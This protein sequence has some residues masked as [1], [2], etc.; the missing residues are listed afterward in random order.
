MIKKS[1]LL[2]ALAIAGFAVTSLAQTVPN[3]VPSNGLV[4]W[5]PFNGNAIDESVNTNDGTVTGATLTADR[6]GSVN[7]AY[8]FDGVNDY[9]EVAHNST[10]DIPNVTISAW[11]NAVSYT[12][13]L[14]GASRLIASK[15][16]ISGW[17][18]SFQFGLDQ[19]ILNNNGFHADWTIGGN[20][21]V[22][23]SNQNLLINNW[24]HAVYVH[25][26][27][28]AFLYLNGNKVKSKSTSGGLTYNTLPLWFGARPNAGNNSSWFS[29]KLDDIGIWNRAL[30]PNEITGLYNA[31]L[32]FQTI[33]VT[34][35]LLIN[36][37]LT[38]FNPIT[39][40][41]TIKIWPNPSNDHITIDNGNL[42]NL[43]GH[44]IKIS[45]ALGQQVFQSAITQQQFYVDMSTWGGN[46]IYF[47]NL[48]NAQGVTIETRKIVLQ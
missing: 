11:Y 40:Q 1:V 9:I 31:N 42:A 45:N 15:R 38:G 28:S 44:Q 47:V 48:I 5:W 39:Y 34:D 32:C 33:T 43:T 30:T 46:G 35:T 16:E 21:G 10:F 7:S 25:R 24:Y 6:F 20:N 13:G 3:Y 18:N 23:Y 26:N 2:T 19:Y 22:Y 14:Q 8:S 4:G 27:D 37:N 12:D 41:N 36:T 29:G 17:G